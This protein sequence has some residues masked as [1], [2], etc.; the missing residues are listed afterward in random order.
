[1]YNLYMIQYF[2]NHQTT[3]CAHLP[4]LCKC[5][6]TLYVQTILTCSHNNMT[7]YIKIFFQKQKEQKNYSLHDHFAQSIS[8]EH[9]QITCMN[10]IWT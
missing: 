6:S 10:Y 5:F 3:K 8:A 4:F 9:I 7:L 1:M 2:S